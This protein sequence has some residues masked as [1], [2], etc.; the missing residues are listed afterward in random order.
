MKKNKVTKKDINRDN[1]FLAQTPQ[2]FEFKTLYKAYLHNKKILDNFT[3]DAQIFAKSNSF[4]HTVKGD[5][6]NTKITTN[7]D[8]INKI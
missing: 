3:D 1:L 8:W 4:I 6:D 7:K 5:V 2:L